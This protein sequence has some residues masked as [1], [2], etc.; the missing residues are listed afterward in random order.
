MYSGIQRT[1]CRNQLFLKR[2]NIPRT[3]RG[4]S[5]CSRRNKP[6]GVSIAR[7]KARSRCNNVFPACAYEPNPRSRSAAA[8]LSRLIPHLH[9]C[10]QYQSK[11]ENRLPCHL[12][13]QATIRSRLIR[14]HSSS[15]QDSRA[16]SPRSTDFPTPAAEAASSL[17]A[18]LPL[19]MMSGA[20]SWDRVNVA[21]DF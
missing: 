1:I 4:L 10:H 11:R 9:A 6:R 8:M 12:N 19:T 20:G 17:L 13:K 18:T 5:D 2:T 15:S 16:K 14:R 3:N 21:V 7:Q